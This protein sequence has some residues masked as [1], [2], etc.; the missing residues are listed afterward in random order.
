MASERTQLF[1]DCDGVLADF[2]R[3]FEET[4]GH[5]PRTF[6]ERHGSNVFWRNIREEAPEFY[7]HLPLMDDARE[8][9]EAVAHLR[10]IILT[11]CP[12]GGWAETQKIAWAKEHFPGVPMVTCRS[13]DKRVYCRPGDILI[14]DWPKYRGLWEDAG[15]KFI[16]HRS[17]SESLATL[18]ALSAQ[19]TTKGAGE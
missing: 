7:R 16:L 13:R 6:E 19:G 17:A 10:P 3:A 2:D 4:F 12:M 14:D 15:G 11:G 8:L 18:K 9:Y 5:A 1:L